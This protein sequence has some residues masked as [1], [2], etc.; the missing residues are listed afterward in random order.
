ML[1]QETYSFLL[2]SLQPWLGNLT[3]YFQGEPYLHPDFLSMV[4]MAVKKGIY[5]ST[6]T[7]AHF[8][9]YDN[10]LKTVRSGLHRIIVSIDGSDQETYEQYRIGGNLE[11]VLEG[12]RNLIRARKELKS[13]TPHIVF[14]FLVVRPNEHQIPEIEKLAKDIGVDELKLKTA[15]IY[16]FENGSDLIPIQDKYSRYS[17]SSNG[18]YRIKNSML[19]QC[20]KMW[21]SAVLTWDGQV[22]PCCF[23]KDAKHSMGT[24]KRL[25]FREIWR[26]NAYQN[27]RNSLLKSRS[28]IEMCNN[29]TEGTRVWAEA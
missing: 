20:W 24:V 6:S 29:C 17:K 11:K 12:T 13:A 3:F 8:L 10:A 14:Q 22:L 15:Q 23:D 5:T 7:N 19:N 16:D 27:F 1:A 18:Q 2:D 4:E 9:K 25:N 26:G 21:H 28:E